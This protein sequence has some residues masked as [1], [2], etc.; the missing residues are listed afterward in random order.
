MK[1]DWSISFVLTGPSNRSG[2]VDYSK[3]ATTANPC[4][5]YLMHTPTS[6][7]SSCK[8]NY[9]SFLTKYRHLLKGQLGRLLIG[10][11]DFKKPKM[12]YT[13]FC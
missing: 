1:D 8:K 7:C 5:K 6:I 3:N 13:L 12:R 4:I 2:G 11:W 9:V 10:Q